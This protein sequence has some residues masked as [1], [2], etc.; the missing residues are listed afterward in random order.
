MS[1]GVKLSSNREFFD[2]NDV[3]KKSYKAKNFYNPINLKLANGNSNSSNNRSRAKT[4]NQNFLDI[5][6]IEESQ[7][8]ES[9]NYKPK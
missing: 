9:I 4:F 8:F 6:N 3:L 2:S 1:S 7:E 5:M